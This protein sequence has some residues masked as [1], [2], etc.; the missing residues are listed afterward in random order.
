MQSEKNGAIRLRD[1]RVSDGDP[2]GELFFE[3]IRVGAAEAYS[4]CE[5]AAWASAPPQGEAWNQRLQQPISLVAEDERGLAGFMTLTAEN[6]IDLAFVRSD[7]IGQG[8][9]KA[10]YD[11]L[12][13]RALALGKKKLFVQASLMARPFFERQGW[14]VREER[15]PVLDGVE[16]TC[17]R[18]EFEA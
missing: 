16:L 7:R 11:E 14:T 2:A 18:M 12:L 15:R 4:E 3:S 10:L 17:F 9:A 5:R 6:C 8:V 1:Y 13:G